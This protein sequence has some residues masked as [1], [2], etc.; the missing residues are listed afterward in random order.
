MIARILRSGAW[1]LICLLLATVVAQAGVLAYLGLRYG[2]SRDKLVQIMAVVQDVDL[3]AIKEAADEEVDDISVEQISYAQVVDARAKM[4]HH[5]ELREQALR[6]VLDMVRAERQKL[7]EER[8]RQEKLKTAFD[9]RLADLQDQ[10]TSEGMADNRSKLESIK[11]KQAKELLMALLDP[12]GDTYAIDDVV[13]LL[14]GMPTVKSAKI[15]TEFKTE[16]EME[17]IGE[18]LSLIRQGTPI[19]GLAAETQQKLQTPQAAGP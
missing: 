7:A 10:A 2:L 19:A 3:F 12:N 18:V 15:I 17:K 9:R 1:A 16:E 14:Q 11:P 8:L 13:I 5:L 6:N 4:I